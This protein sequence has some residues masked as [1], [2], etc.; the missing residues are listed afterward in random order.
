MTLLKSVST[1]MKS[2]R[3]KFLSEVF[4]QLTGIGVVVVVDVVV[5]A[6][7]VVVD[8]V[9]PAIV[10][11]VLPVARVVLPE[12]A[13]VV[14]VEL[15]ATCLFLRPVGAVVGEMALRASNLIPRTEVPA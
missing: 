13:S 4:K 11:V 6:S 8:P 12:A 1:N 7:V 5:V 14:V 9:A 2:F 15:L 10:V 3:N